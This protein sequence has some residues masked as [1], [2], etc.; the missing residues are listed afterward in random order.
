M[1]SKR[2]KADEKLAEEQWKG[3]RIDFP[4]FS[5]ALSKRR[6]ELG[7]KEPAHPELVEGRNSGER[8]TE[9][10]KALLK[11]ITDIGGKW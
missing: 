6:A 9:S 8:R 1:A 10:K 3:R 5:D 2:L 11:A 4:A 7:M